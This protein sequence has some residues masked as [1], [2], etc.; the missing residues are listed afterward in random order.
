MEQ[1][2]QKLTM[3][4][5]DV[6]PQIIPEGDV[7]EGRALGVKGQ[8]TLWP[9]K[10]AKYSVSGYYDDPEAFRRDIQ[11]LEKMKP[12]GCYFTLHKLHPGVIGRALNCF[13]PDCQATTDKDVIAFRYLP[14]DIDPVRPSGI[15]SSDAELAAALELRDQIAKYAMNQ[16]G[17]PEPIVAVS[18]NGGH[19]LFRLPDLP[20]SDKNSRIFIEGTLKKLAE[21]F[22]N[23]QA[24]VDTAIHNP[25]R[26]FKIYG[27]V[28]RKGYPVPASGNG[29]VA[30]PHRMS[31]IE[32]IPKG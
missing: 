18:G 21:K 3:L 1:E 26:I 22:D 6:Y 5:E 4:E 9:G 8:S 27:T 23:E 32:I 11:I 19:L 25:S 14:V 15:S 28:A 17:F 12:S 13:D 7:V 16:L 2:K 20:T 29:R 31:Y 24:K 10:W 30:R